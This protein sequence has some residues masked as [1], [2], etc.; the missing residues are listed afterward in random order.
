MMLYEQASTSRAW[1]VRKISL[2]QKLVLSHKRVV[3]YTPVAS[4]ITQPTALPHV[5]LSCCCASARVAL[6]PYGGCPDASDHHCAHD[7]CGSSADVRPPAVGLALAWGPLRVAP[8]GGLEDALLMNGMRMMHGW[9]MDA[10][11]DDAWID[12]LPDLVWVQA[13]APVAWG[14]WVYSCSPRPLPL[15]CGAWRPG[16]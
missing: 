13:A 2:Q 11:M 3:V 9:Q 15:H 6:L 14:L 16:V 1:L 8:A 10:W 12:G 7:C 5:H 4:G